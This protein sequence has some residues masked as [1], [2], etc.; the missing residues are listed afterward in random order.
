MTQD[1]QPAVGFVSPAPGRF[2]TI[3]RGVI[4]LAT[5][6]CWLFGGLALAVLVIALLAGVFDRFLFKIGLPWP[7]ELGRLAL[8]WLTFI[9]AIVAMAQGRHFAI[10]FQEDPS[11]QPL[12]MRALIALATATLAV[13]LAY[14]GWL[15]L[16]LVGGQT[17]AAFDISVTWMYLPFII[18]ACATAVLEALMLLAIAIRLV[19]P[20]ARPAPNNA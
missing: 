5:W 10:A 15:M 1:I 6:A 12:P 16:D 3:H 2:G 7:E 13:F 20:A 18:F 8:I 19:G 17:M 14:Q 4:R 9:G 11:A